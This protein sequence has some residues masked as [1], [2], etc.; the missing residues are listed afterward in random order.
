M[1]GREYFTLQDNDNT[2]IVILKDGLY[3]IKCH[4]MIYNNSNSSTCHVRVDGTTKRSSQNSTTYSGDN[5]HYGNHNID[6]A[7]NLKSNQKLDV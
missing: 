4:L 3:R 7:L 6:T 2:K 1:T 5:N